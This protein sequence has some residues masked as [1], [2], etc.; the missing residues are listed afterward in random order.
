M[1][2]QFN[3]HFSYSG[4]LYKAEIKSYDLEGTFIYDVYYSPVDKMNPVEIIQIYRGSVP[5]QQKVYWRQRIAGTE[6]AVK[7]PDFINAIGR[8]IELEEDM[9]TK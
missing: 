1:L 4:F 6:T 5:G 9:E 2:F 7:D 3:I 8:S